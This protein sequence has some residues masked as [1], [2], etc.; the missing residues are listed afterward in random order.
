[1]LKADFAPDDAAV[2]AI[3]RG[4]IGI[5][6][7]RKPGHKGPHG[8]GR[9]GENQSGDLSFRKVF[10]CSISKVF[11]PKRQ[12]GDAVGAL[13]VSHRSC[14]GFSGF[15]AQFNRVALLRN[16]FTFNTSGSRFS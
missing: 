3:T 5:T 2:K 14:P 11:G 6:V 13:F 4:V 8:K 16:G 1:L 15:L 9:K 12:R 10:P 7:E